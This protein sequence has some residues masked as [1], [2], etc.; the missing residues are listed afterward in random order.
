MNVEPFLA[1]IFPEILEDLGL[2]LG[3][4]RWPDAL[5]GDG[6]A[7]G[8]NTDFLRRA[9]DHWRQGFDWHAAEAR[10]NALPQY[11]AVVEGIGLH[12]VHA[13]SDRA[14]AVP[15]LL[16]NG[17]PSSIFEYLEI[18]PRLQAA[19]FH[20]IAPAHPGYGFSDRPRERGIS[21]RRIAGLYAKLVEALGYP[22]VIAH[23]SDIGAGILEQMRRRHPERLL[24]AHFS[25]VYWAYPRPADPSPEVEAYFA[26]IDSW[27]A[28]E[29]AYAM[30]QRTKP[31]TL[32]YGLN[33]S[34]AGLAAW[35]LEKFHGW[36]DGDPEAVIGLDSLCANLTLYWATQTIGSSVRLYA[37][38]AS[39][40]DAHTPAPRRGEVPAGVIVFPRDILPAPRVWGERWLNLV[41]FTQAARGGHFP[42]W[43]APDILADDLI[44][45]AATLARG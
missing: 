37:E 41:H 22:Q 14:G 16:M 4:T 39:D 26:G 6:W 33:D 44:L 30:L 2:R 9:C 36:T 40:P 15:L 42:A 1:D 28:C 20:V 17:W 32:A 38:S 23:G 34:P 11:R 5:E 18:I 19:G 31:Q 10:L 12:F 45:F 7:L 8:T 21:S 13:R 29:G 43:E 3:R 24:G 35:V 25:N 27:A